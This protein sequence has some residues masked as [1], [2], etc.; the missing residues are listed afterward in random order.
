MAEWEAFNVL[1]PIGEERRDYRFSYLMSTISNI[2]ISAFGGKNPK[3]TKVQD[4]EF[5][6]DGKKQ[7][8]SQSTESMKNVLMGLVNKK[9]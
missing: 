9:G 1:E 8:P 2:A 6:W 3:L 7:K 5:M 4:F